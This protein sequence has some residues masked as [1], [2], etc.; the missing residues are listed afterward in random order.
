MYHLDILER[1][2]RNIKQLIST[3]STSCS[4]HNQAVSLI[5]VTKT[6]PTE[7]I[8][9]LYSFGQRD[10]AENRV[11]PFL[12]KVNAMKADYSDIIWHYIGHIQTRQVKV[13]IDYVDYIHSLDRLSLAHEIQKRASQP[14]KCFLQVN[15]SGE[16]S[17]SGFPPHEVMDVITQL[18]SYSN[19]IIVGLMTMAPYQESSDNVL[20]YFS[21]LK[22]L[23]D[24]IQQQHYTHAPCELLSMG[25][26]DDY[27]LAIQCGATHVRIGS[28]LFQNI[29]TP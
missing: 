16:S 23:R 13:I 2:Y 14:I 7:V 27:P 19:I 29:E 22:K 11:T 25:M 8:Q 12:E 15:V 9:A 20:Y 24:T 6:V 5:S 1:N 26:S 4:L 10:F 21:K 3:Q 18:Q 17:K 28:A